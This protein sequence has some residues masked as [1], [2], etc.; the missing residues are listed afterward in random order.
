MFENHDSISSN[1]VYINISI[2]L[3]EIKVQYYFFNKIS[4][5]Q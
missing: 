2:I 4:G 3:D 5:A 1:I